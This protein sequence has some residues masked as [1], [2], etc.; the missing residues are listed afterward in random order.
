MIMEL[1]DLVSA[2]LNWFMNFLILV[3]FFLKKFIITSVIKG[4][5]Q[6][7]GKSHFSQLNPD[8]PF[9]FSSDWQ[10]YAS[11]VIYNVWNHIFHIGPEISPVG[12]DESIFI[13][14][15]IDIHT[16]IP[17]II[18][19]DMLNGTDQSWFLLSQL[20]GGITDCESVT[21]HQRKKKVLPVCKEILHD[22]SLK[23]HATG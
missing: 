11:K 5:C 12:G 2:N 23:N 22:Q 8:W 17:H 14:I 18:R 20:V 6:C 19:Y 7:P 16:H 1:E 3:S 9:C 10:T 21:I 13:T 15:Q 4:W